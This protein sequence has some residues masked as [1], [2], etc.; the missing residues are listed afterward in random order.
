[1]G[2]FLL[3]GT[4]AL[5]I[6]STQTAVAQIDPVGTPI[7]GY[8]PPATPV[9]PEDGYPA[10]QP[11]PP[12]PTPTDGAYIPPTEVVPPPTAP[13]V[14]GDEAP[15]PTAVSTPP[16]S[17]SAVVRNR[18]ILW[19]GFLITLLLFLIAVYGAIVMYTRQRSS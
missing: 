13:S 18:A 8:P 5:F 1:M 17:Q 12:E 2:V 10:G 3:L 7:N 6:L 16:I 19:A 14:I 4:M 9:Q 11:T 15:V